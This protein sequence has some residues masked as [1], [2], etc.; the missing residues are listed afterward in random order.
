MLENQI[1]QFKK[2]LKNL[3]YIDLDKLYEKEQ[4]K[5]CNDTD[6]MLENLTYC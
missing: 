1:K 5:K 3:Q 2:A 6:F 4:S